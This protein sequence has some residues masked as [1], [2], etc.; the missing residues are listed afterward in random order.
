MLPGEAGLGAVLA[1]RARAH[2]DRLLVAERG[3]GRGHLGAQ[4]VGQRRALATAK[5]GG[6][7]TPAASSSPSDALLPPKRGASARRRSAS[8]RVCAHPAPSPSRI[9][10]VPVEPSTRR[11]WPV[12]IRAVAVPVPTTAG[13]PYSRRDDRGVG[14]DPAD[15]GDGGR[16]LGEDRR[17]RRR[18]DRAHEDLPGAHRVEVAEPAHHAGRALDLAGRGRRAAQLARRRRR[19]RPLLE[20]LRRDAPEHHHD[21]VVH[22]L[23]HRAERRRR[24]PVAEPL[25][26]LLAARHD[27]RPVV[28]GRAPGRRWTT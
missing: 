9:V 20:A 14:H 11:R 23:G 21:R 13:S 24:R 3:V 8:G 10:T 25:E 28:P 26:Q 6:T 2:R 27:R 22:R 1:E 17:P 19:P 12:S 18:G 16:D 15:V 5:P 7:G 4:R